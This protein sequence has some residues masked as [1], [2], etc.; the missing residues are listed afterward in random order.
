MSIFL[1]TYFFDRVL[2]QLLSERFLQFL[3]HVLKPVQ[4]RGSRLRLHAG[5]RIF[6]RTRALHF[7]LHNHVRKVGVGLIVATAAGGGA[8][9]LS[10]RARACF[11][12]RCLLTREGVRRLTASH[13][14]A[15][16]VTVILCRLVGHRLDHGGHKKK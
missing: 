5:L 1:Q 4:R 14:L 7:S 11:L 9:T 6:R 16:C 15:V 10:I 12:P 8:M 13:A 3:S 2:S